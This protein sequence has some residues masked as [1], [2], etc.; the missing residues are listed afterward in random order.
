M[1]E[2]EREKIISCFSLCKT[3]RLVLL[4]G[5]LFSLA[6]ITAEA[7][8]QPRRISLKL[9]NVDVLH[10]LREVNRMS[11][12]Q[13][14]FKNEEVQKEKVKVSVNLTNVT[15]L[16]AV[17]AVL[18]N[19][20]L[21]HT[22]NGE[23]IIVSPDSSTPHPNNKQKPASPKVL[24]GKV[25]DEN[26]EP[27]VGASILISGTNTGGATD[28]NGAFSIETSGVNEGAT[29]RVSYLGYVP[30][31]LP[32]KSLIN[33]VIVLQPDANT[34]SDVVV[35]GYQT[36]QRERM[37][38]V[39]TTI[40]SAQIAN[41]GFTNIEQ[42]L[43]GTISG[44][45]VTTTGR[46][47]QDTQIMIRG[48]NS[49]TGSTE[50]M[51]I[52][53][54]M[55]MQGDVPNVS[56]STDLRTNIIT[57]GI[58]NISPDDIRSIT[59]LKDAAATA[60]YG[61]RAANGVI[62]IE[63]KSGLE[64]KT[65]FSVSAN[66]GITDRP[67]NNVSM[68]SSAQKIKFERQILSDQIGYIY[69]PGRVTSLLQKLTYQEITEAEAENEIARLSGINTNWFKEIFKPAFQQQYN[70]TMSGGDAKTQYYA[71]LNYLDQTGIEP[72]NAYDRIGMNIK[73]SHAPRSNIHISGGIN[74]TVRNDRS[75]ASEI[76]PL[77]YA[78][79]ANPYERP[80]NEDGSYAYDQS[81]DPTQSTLREDLKWSTLN[82][83]EDMKRNTQTQR[84]LNLQLSLKLEWEIIKG[85][86]FATHGTY[87]ANSNNTRLVEGEN[88]YTNFKRNWLNNYMSEV[89]L[90]LVR[91]S[92]SESNGYSTNYTWRN[93]LQ[94][95]CEFNDK[96]Y[97]TLFAG[98]EIWNN[99]GYT[100]SN[101]YPVFDEKHR[102]GGYPDMSGID[103]SEIDLSSFGGTG[104][105]VQKMSSFFGNASYSYMDKYIFTGSMRYDGSDIIGNNNQFTPLW[106][107]GARWNLHKENFLKDTKWINQLSIRSGFGYTG[108]IDKNAL[109]FLT[110]TMGQS[111]RYDGQIIPTSFSYPNYNI[112]WQTK[113]D[114]NVGL[115]ILLFDYRMELGFN[116]YHNIS[117]DVLDNM[118]LPQSSGRRV[119]KSNVANI[120][121]RG[122][123]IDLGLTLLRK[124]DLQWY[125]KFNI[126][127]NDNEVRNTYYKSV[128]DLPNVRFTQGA[129]FVENYPVGSWFGYK[130]AGVDPITGYV[131]VYTGNGDATHAMGLSGSGWATPR[132]SYLGKSIPPV[133]GGFSTSVNW[134]QFVV[135]ANFEFKEGHK[136]T[137]FNTFR[138]LDSKNRH[139]VDENRW[140]QPGDVSNIP[141][142]SEL[143][144]SYS[145]YMYDSRLE[146]GDYLRCSYLNVG[147]DIKSPALK[148]V[149]FS[150]ARVSLTGNNLFTL[151]KYKGIDPSL[152]GQTGYPVS[153]SYI[154]T[155]N[156]GF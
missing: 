90:D 115:D 88:T 149:G 47:G 154:F 13:I 97:L 86:M 76:D 95:S 114:F 5:L 108:S 138:R 42:A 155:L 127:M 38:G 126:T 141:M 1:K 29:A 137:S 34:I 43:G 40:T 87:S 4:T 94:Y 39:T 8:T 82:A 134:K 37:T 44:L 21:N 20:N 14:M 129:Q 15:V 84:Y 54:G 145:L 98:Q 118:E 74:G 55:P 122:V 85:L 151:S 128:D 64:G 112:K 45:N 11:G 99:T 146:K 33:A 111:L 2:S 31:H 132:A 130:F 17:E 49:L 150:T 16:E 10:A 131:L 32:L 79:Y 50:P 12:N 143:S 89:P 156:L 58:G 48:A 110:M 6:I 63:T 147:Y 109:P 83:I 67:S 121:N 106:N 102:V 101:Y 26:G 27:L 9:T 104:K 18:R 30:Q 91:G 35:T 72:N 119:I 142:L 117:R 23:V 77:S 100:S 22:V 56:M 80:Y 70:F 148:Q 24:T 25:Q 59:V 46:P 19:T 60:I 75:S 123:E 133:T 136:I 153:R 139:S 28:L 116:Y 135:S 92:L 62:V 81:W 144:T 103:G 53:D 107:V 124:K 36:I 140:R 125:A 73:L 96:H 93:T 3:K 152:M 69:N 71:S 65:R 68:M 51:W 78:L 52:V 41:K 61:A 66:F 120:Y 105:N 7:Q 57:T 113:Q